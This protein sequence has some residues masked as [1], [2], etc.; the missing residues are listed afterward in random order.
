MVQR[1]LT[2]PCRLS[3]L[4]LAG[5]CS[6]GPADRGAP[7]GSIGVTVVSDGWQL[8][9]DL[10][11]GS[12]AASAPAVL[13]LNQAGGARAA[14]AP[15]AGALA[16]RGIASLRIDLRGHGESVNL[17]AF[18]PGEADALD[19]LKG[20]EHD[21]AAALSFLA[22]SAGID[23]TRIAVVGAS[24]S[25]EIAVLATRRERPAQAYVLLSPGSLS[26]A[27]VEW[28]DR[29]DAPWL[30]VASRLERMRAV[31]DVIEMVLKSARRADVV[32]L[33]RPSGHATDLLE[34]HPG[35]AE[36]LAAWLSARLQP[37]R[38]D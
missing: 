8:I 9:G 24:Y 35:L 28:L 4:L 3:L 2:H 19:L 22:H 38:E 15:L 33:A 5:A 23:S 30:F 18:V 1:V 10:V 37:P 17:G 32:L 7:E 16:R 21:V 26:A 36:Q 25:G 27:S 14:Y 31:R 13:L 11:R 29:L 12:P 34:N 6:G 20:T